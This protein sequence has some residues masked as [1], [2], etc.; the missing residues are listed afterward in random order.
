MARGTSRSSHVAASNPTSSLE[1]VHYLLAKCPD[2]IGGLSG[3]GSPPLAIQNYA[4]SL[5]LCLA[6]TVTATAAQPNKLNAIRCIIRHW[7]GSLHERSGLG[8]L[9]LH[10]A[11]RSCMSAQIVQFFLDRLPAVVPDGT[12]SGMLHYAIAF[13]W[14]N[15]ELGAKA[16]PESVFAMDLHG[17]L[18]V[19]VAVAR[20]KLNLVRG[21]SEACPASLLVRNG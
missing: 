13:A 12:R 8:L 14:Q 2:V 18:P 11:I 9:P 19:H 7:P 10:Q 17:M 6:A 1:A 15:V 5:L 20:D 3:R 16:I 4:V 21:F